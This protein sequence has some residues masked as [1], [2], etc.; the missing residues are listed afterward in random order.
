MQEML[1]RACQKRRAAC[2]LLLRAFSLL[3]RRLLQW[4]ERD[5]GPLARFLSKYYL[6]TVG[7]EGSRW[8]ALR[9]SARPFPSRAAIPP[10]QL[11]E[12]SLPRGRK[13]ERYMH[14]WSRGVFLNAMVGFL[15]WQALGRPDWMS[16][17][18]LGEYVDA[19]A[20]T[21]ADTV[22]SLEPSLRPVTK[23]AV[24][25]FRDG[26]A[27]LSPETFA[28]VS[29]GRA[30]TAEILT[31]LMGMSVWYQGVFSADAIT[32]LLRREAEETNER[33][34]AS[35]M[36]FIAERQGL[37]AKSALIP[38]ET[39]LPE[40]WVAVLEN[41]MERLV[42]TAPVGCCPRR[43]HAASESEWE[44]LVSRKAGSK[45]MVG[46]AKGL[47]PR[48]P[49]NEELWSGA[50]PVPK[51]KEE[52]RSIDDRR[53][54][55]LAEKRWRGRKPGHG[56]HYTKSLLCPGRRRKSHIGDA[57]HFYHNIHGGR[58]HAVHNPTG[59]PIRRDR[60]VALGLP[61]LAEF[62]DGGEWIQPCTVSIVMGDAKG[63]TLA[64][65]AHAG[66]LKA[67]GLREEWLATWDGPDPA[68]TIRASL[69]IDRVLAEGDVPIEQ[70]DEV[71]TEADV[72]MSGLLEL[73]EELGIPP[74]AS[75]VQWNKREVISPRRKERRRAPSLR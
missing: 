74:K 13:R 19:V 28:G 47:V 61:M 4:S 33:V 64:S 40:S 57:P 72:F 39:W 59:P 67:V 34:G 11:L 60:A 30:T 3:V 21:D 73:C 63:V 65:E 53:R 1:C 66:M 42:D 62:D 32:G 71:V 7:Y 12:S 36:E 26:I 20:K 9:G 25:R 56:C 58:K 15:S 46:V 70:A 10:E 16:P 68:G 48:G 8:A 50:F 52:D 75:K 38:V 27:R 24:G 37:P 2:G 6:P 23:E 45:M 22:D 17:A 49:R 41:P 14:R 44:K 35:R 31:G 69:C 29:G 18:A 51:S 55:N 5:P 54:K 43:Y